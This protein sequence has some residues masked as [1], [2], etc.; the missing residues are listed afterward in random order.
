MIKSSGRCAMVRSFPDVYISYLEYINV[1]IYYI[2][3]YRYIPNRSEVGVLSARTSLSHKVPFIRSQPWR[4]RHF[5][6]HYIYIYNIP[7]YYIL[8]IYVSRA[9][10]VPET[11]VPMRPIYATS[12]LFYTTRRK[13]NCLDV[14]TAAAQAITLVTTYTM[15]AMAAVRFPYIIIYDMC[16]FAIRG[17]WIYTQ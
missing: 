6:E 5:L 16:I 15:A 17:Q 13:K 7:S 9:A 12:L 3:T 10:I 14:V 2:K 11:T 1:Y 8:F 4:V